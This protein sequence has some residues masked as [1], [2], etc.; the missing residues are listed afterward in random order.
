MPEESPPLDGSPDAREPLDLLLE[1]SVALHKHGMYPPGHPA[2]GQLA[3]GLMQR[4]APLLAEQETVA[5]GVAR[6]QLTLGAVTTDVAH[7]VLRRLAELLHGKQL[8]GVTIAR[9]VDVAEIGDV[10]RVLAEPTTDAAAVLLAPPDI[11]PH[12]RLHQLTFDHLAIAAQEGAAAV[13]IGDELWLEISR[14]A[15]EGGPADAVDADDPRA[16]ARAIDAPQRADAADRAVAAALRR[17]VEALRAGHGDT[18][19]ALRGRMSDLIGALHPSTLRR[20]VRGSREG[21]ASTFLRDAVESLRMDAVVEVLRATAPVHGETI[22]HGLLRMWMKLATQLAGARGS[23]VASAAEADVR[24]HVTRLIADWK[25]ADPNPEE[26]GRKLQRFATAAQ[27]TSARVRASAAPDPIRL[28]QMGLEVDELGVLARRAVVT[29][30]AAGR[31]S[32][33]VALLDH[34]PPG[35]GTAAAALEASLHSAGAL[36]ALLAEEP[37][38]VAAL[39]RLLPA[40]SAD[41]CGPLIDALSNSENRMTRRRLLDRLAELPQDLSPLI[42][43]RLDDSRWHVQRNLLLL[44]ERRATLPAGFTPRPWL[45][46]ADWRV[47][48]EAVRLALGMPAER[49]HG[50]RLALGDP[51]SSI[52]M[53]GLTALGETPGGHLDDVAHLAANAELPEDARALAVRVLAGARHPDV[54][55]LQTLT[56][57]LDG[58][59]TMLGRQKLTAPTPLALAALTALVRHYAAAPAAVPFLKAARRSSYADVRAAVAA[60]HE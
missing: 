31:V 3:D 8:G 25:L 26:Y 50:L 6:R 47:R 1:L 55:V 22:S 21:S 7:P 27:R 41:D 57:L 30:I 17:V 33:L 59:R 13:T 60:R 35:A 23:T 5:I 9:G 44:L 10:L 58:G 43:A 11:W 53:L 54:L 49:A 12:V 18:V 48:I 52:V 29:E 24:D 15:L 51:H 37:V 46:H 45:T 4:L 56:T 38:N 28:V 19:E 42:L 20:L 39:D 14:A 16:L 36:T 2:L 40:L 32:S 34:P